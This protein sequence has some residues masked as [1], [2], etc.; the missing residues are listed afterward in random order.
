MSR[1]MGIVL[2]CGGWDDWRW[3]EVRLLPQIEL[4]EHRNALLRF[5]LG[6]YEEVF[7]GI[8]VIV[9]SMTWATTHARHM[10]HVFYA[11]CCPSRSS[12]THLS[13]YIDSF[14]LDGSTHTFTYPITT[15][16]NTAFV[17]LSDSTA[18]VTQ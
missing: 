1:I 6:C 3:I 5:G 16:E 2:C 15:A 13:L 12:H 10:S 17:T 11:L 18:N 4:S 7:E 9:T 14:A 8:V